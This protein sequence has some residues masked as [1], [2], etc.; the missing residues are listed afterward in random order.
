MQSS[1]HRIALLFGKNKRCGYCRRK[2][3]ELAECPVGYRLYQIIKAQNIWFWQ[4]RLSAHLSSFLLRAE[5]WISTCLF[6]LYSKSHHVCAPPKWISG[7]LGWCV[8]QDNILS[9]CSLKESIKQTRVVVFFLL[10]LP[11]Q[12]KWCTHALWGGWERLKIT[13]NIAR[14]LLS[15]QP[16]SPFIRGNAPLVILMTHPPYRGLIVCT[17]TPPTH[18]LPTSPP[19]SPPFR[20]NL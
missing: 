5:Q 17:N 15:T 6:N 13:W 9:V 8:Q 11:S 20:C 2:N 10:L 4:M 18:S 1:T 16:L 19:S 14:N 12:L 3:K 7:E